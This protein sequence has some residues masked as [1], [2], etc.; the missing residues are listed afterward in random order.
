MS[1]ICDDNFGAR[2]ISPLFNL[3]TQTKVDEIRSTRHIDMSYI[4]FLECLARI[5]DK[6]VHPN[7]SEFPIELDKDK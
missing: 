4:E 7:F 3:A 1:G 6:A 5:A 2:E